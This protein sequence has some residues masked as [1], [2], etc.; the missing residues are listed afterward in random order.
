MNSIFLCWLS[1][2]FFFAHFTEP[3]MYQ[4]P[5]CPNEPPYAGASG[6]W[7]HMKRHHG[8]VTR[9]YNKAKNGKPEKPRTPKKKKVKVKKVKQ[10]KKDKVS[11]SSS[12]GRS[13]FPSSPRFKSVRR[14]QDDDGSNAHYS[15]D[16]DEE[17][18]SDED[19]STSTTTSANGLIGRP[20]MISLN[21]SNMQLD[22]LRSVVALKSLNS[23]PVAAFRQRKRTHGN[24]NR[25]S[26]NFS[27]RTTSTTSSVE[28]STNSS[29]SSNSRSKFPSGSEMMLL[30]EVALLL[31]TS[32]NMQSK[33][34][35][36]TTT[37]TATTTTTEVSMDDNNDTTSM[38]TSNSSSNSSSSS[39]SS[40]TKKEPHS[41]P[42]EVRAV[43]AVAVDVNAQLHQQTM[44]SSSY[45]T[46]SRE[47]SSSTASDTSD[48]A[49]T[50]PT[51]KKGVDNAKG[52]LSPS[53]QKSPLPPSSDKNKLISRA[54]EMDD[55][56][57]EKTNFSNLV[58]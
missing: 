3:R 34:V 43:A 37:T 14:P 33:V 45:D 5:H 31:G 17:Y 30:S 55:Q 26:L 23:S 57:G 21:S 47:I 48:D 42:E 49:S 38:D 51:P 10:A 53:T 28:E 29:S 36:K 12:N 40:N 46:V 11:S 1:I 41:S 15:D 2:L 9:P 27:D 24:S 32:R 13:K 20:S 25:S 7:Y 44:S 58:L 54:L 56:G 16:S 22:D 6:L 52:S 35:L 50:K 18:D 4:C 19:L 8:A 39:S